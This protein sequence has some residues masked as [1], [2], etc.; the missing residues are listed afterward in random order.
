MTDLIHIDNVYA[1][2]EDFK[3][4][5]I[6]DVPAHENGIKKN[7][8]CL[9]CKRQMQAVK[10]NIRKQH[11][12]HHV[13]PNSTEK[14]CTYRDET[15][16][17]KLA[18]DII[19]GLKK[20]K[21][22]P[23]YKF[24][25]DNKS[26]QALLIQESQ[27]VEAHEV[28]IERHIYENQNGEIE[29]IHKEDKTK[30]LLIKPDAILLDKNKK[31]ILIIEFVATHKPDISKLIKLKRLG[32][33]AIQLSIPK[34][35]PEEIEKSFSI[36]KH[37]KWL[38][39]NE[40]SNTDY[41]QFSNKYSGAI[42]EVDQEQRKLFEEG[43][44]CRSSEIGDLI[45][46]IERLLE[47]EQYKGIKQS[48]RS[49][50]Q[51]VEGNSKS[52]QQE[53]EN[54]REG[55]IREGIEIHSDRREQLTHSQKEFSSYSSDLEERYLKKNGDLELEE[56]AID[57]SIAEIEFSIEKF[58]TTRSTTRFDVED[59]EE[60]TDTIRREIELLDL[61]EQ[62]NSEIERESFERTK[63][64]LESQI[65]RVRNKIETLSEFYTEEEREL[66]EQFKSLT[67]IEKIEIENIESEETGIPEYIAERRRSIHKQF[68]LDR[69]QLLLELE[70]GEDSTIRGI[71][72]EHRK[73]HV[74]QQ[75]IMVY[76]TALKQ[77]DR[78][79]EINNGRAKK[80]RSND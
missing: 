55:Y 31:P 54:V 41:V 17:H 67:R 68:E 24:D 64:E 43:Y 42:F 1:Y 26:N 8:Y 40:E 22:P 63:R 18:K 77:N 80:S 37:T 58:N 32:I 28:L 70:K 11:F 35:S 44:K 50:I 33:D 49:E 6:G 66:D 14:K 29:I 5:Y 74:F 75:T 16:R 69:E 79:K 34:S 46:T 78:I 3:E 60:T 45:R 62:N 12:K 51:R 48:L 15:Y 57:Q 36:T 56:A 52:A 38:F 72:Q 39:N 23:V 59:A 10:G 9:G 53:L 76:N 71:A 47:T 61:R 73:L 20:I 65:E 21:V 30:N 25:P 2:N 7:Y 27:F 19:Q 4:I 13:K